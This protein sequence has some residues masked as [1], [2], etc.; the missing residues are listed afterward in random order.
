MCW[1]R[2]LSAQISLTDISH[3]SQKPC[4]PEPCILHPKCTHSCSRIASPHGWGIGCSVSCQ[5]FI[6][7]VG[8]SARAVIKVNTET[9]ALQG[10]KVMG[11][12]SHGASEKIS[13][14]DAP[15]AT[16]T[17]EGRHSPA[18]NSLWEDR[19]GKG[20][21]GA[22]SAAVCD[23]IQPALKQDIPQVLLQLSYWHFSH[24]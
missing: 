6:S 18:R 24:F 4:S 5:I 9:A 7:W 15:L 16:H 11:K 17:M 13:A 20:R 23:T 2:R 22:G 1:L 8:N 3:H 10:T 19:S 14:L 12:A 21:E